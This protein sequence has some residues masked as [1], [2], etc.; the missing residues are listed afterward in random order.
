VAPIYSLVIA[1]EPLPAAT[2]ER[3]GLHRRETF[4]YLE[5]RKQTYSW[6]VR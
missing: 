5:L 3:I 6:G 2:W 1:T 4:M